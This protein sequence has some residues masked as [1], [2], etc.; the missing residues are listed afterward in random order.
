MRYTYHLDRSTD[1]CPWTEAQRGFEMLDRDVGLPGPY[2]DCTADVPA[3]SVARVE[4][5]RAV[6]QRDRHPYI[7]AEK[8]Q[9]MRRRSQGAGIVAGDFKGASGEIDALKAVR[10]RVFAEAVANQT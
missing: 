8:R 2:P 6:D 1:A 7:L 4:R 3:A 9:G 5:Q 10:C